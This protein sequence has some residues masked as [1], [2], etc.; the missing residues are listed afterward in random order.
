VLL[1]GRSIMAY[2]V[3]DTISLKKQTMTSIDQF[4]QMSSIEAAETL[5]SRMYPGKTIHGGFEAGPSDVL[6]YS[7][8]PNPLIEVNLDLTNQA[9][10]HYFD[11]G[12]SP[13]E[14]DERNVS[15]S[16]DTLADVPLRMISDP[17][18]HNETLIDKSVQKALPPG[19]L[20]AT[21]INASNLYAM[22]KDSGDEAAAENWNSE[23]NHLWGSTDELDLDVMAPL[24][25]G[26]ITK[27]IIRHQKKS[28]YFLQTS[29]NIIPRITPHLKQYGTLFSRG[30]LAVD[31]ARIIH[32]ARSFGAINLEFSPNLAKYAKKVKIKL[33]Y[34]LVRCAMNL[35]ELPVHFAIPHLEASVS[36]G[37][38]DH[39][40]F[41]LAQL[42]P[43]LI[44]PDLE[45][46]L[47]TLDPEGLE[48]P[49]EAYRT[50]VKGYIMQQKHIPVAPKPY[51]MSGPLI[52]IN[53]LPKK[54]VPYWDENVKTTWHATKAGL[55]IALCKGPSP[56]FLTYANWCSKH[57]KEIRTEE[58]SFDQ[59]DM[60]LAST[61]TFVVPMVARSI[62]EGF[63]LV[64]GRKGNQT[65]ISQY[66]KKANLNISLE[67]A[68][69]SPIALLDTVYY[70]EHMKYYFAQALGKVH[71]KYVYFKDKDSWLIKGPI[72]NLLADPKNLA[73]RVANARRLYWLDNYTQRY[74]VT[75]LE[76][77]AGWKERSIILQQRMS[78]LSKL[79]FTTS[80]S[81]G[82]LNPNRETS[83]RLVLK[84]SAVKYAK[85]RNKTFV[86]KDVSTEELA[87]QLDLTFQPTV[88]WTQI[89]SDLRRISNELETDA[90]E[91]YRHLSKGDNYDSFHSVPD[92]P[93]K[94]EESI[95]NTISDAVFEKIIAN[96]NVEEP[97]EVEQEEDPFNDMC[98]YALAN[99]GLDA[100]YVPAFIQY[101]KS[102]NVD[103]DTVEIGLLEWQ[104]APAF[105]GLSQQKS[106]FID[107]L[108]EEEE[109]EDYSNP[110]LKM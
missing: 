56:K 103:T 91:L 37:L 20:S 2:F 38:R 29:L 17:G 109:G 77:L 102:E 48:G 61:K 52:D 73:S 98:A 64:M 8:D 80:T 47:S 66:L 88:S 60:I 22:L 68:P 1:L 100:S 70:A 46:E 62:R 89:L 15:I 32:L 26:D 108:K 95:P 104:Y 50:A 106:R 96:Q 74:K 99:Y 24:L 45:K 79:T 27:H 19:P 44:L 39:M 67:L 36:P 43:E 42:N 57:L 30:T 12:C 35:A 63:I 4:L 93:T 82:L 11:W 92:L 5:W 33:G 7:L 6:Q 101:M 71:K 76:K 84:Q 59:E 81:Y 34:N 110:F 53:R 85:H 78:F 10:N 16:D 107:N 40:V 41:M 87:S 97:P 49:T 86:L 18:Y 14:L 51:L 23:F 28:T 75:K 69:G 3:E 105:A 90:V 83:L 9:D 54:A 13:Q 65:M 58:L 72:R 25:K 31:W 21:L 55:L 94:E